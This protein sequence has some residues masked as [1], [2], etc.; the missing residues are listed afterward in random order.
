MAST[1]VHDRT[2]LITGASSGIGEAFAHV[3][4]HAG[5]NLVV[6]ARREA[7]LRALADRLT[8]E[9]GVVVH[10]IATDLTSPGAAANLVAEIAE[11][12]LT[13]DALVNS[14][15]FGVPGT[16]TETAWTTHAAMVQLNATAVAE[17]THRLMPG[18]LARGYG[19]IINV[20][21]LAGLVPAGAGA[22]YGA[23]K[24]FVVNLSTSL[25]REVR[26][27]GVHVTVVCPGLTRTHFHDAP[28]LRATVLRMP[29]WAWMD[30]QTVAKQ[31]FLA[32]MGGAPVCV[33]GF[34]N[35]ALVLALT[36][37]PHSIARTAGRLVMSV[38][39]LIG[40]WRARSIARVRA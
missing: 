1:R 8:H 33:N 32:V 39:P 31:G 38:Y 37:V 3:F 14:A 4:A 5:F 40:R 20:A 21:S 13:I 16:Y 26:A 17:L 15:G 10:V 12:G 11:R 2:A 29:R 35:K 9:C 22:L 27:R 7:P 6:T 28:E 30:P 18:M 25:A 24:A 34:Q 19:R 36:Y 23:S